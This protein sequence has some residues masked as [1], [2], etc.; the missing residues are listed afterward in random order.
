MRLR[1]R[2][3]D[4]RMPRTEHRAQFSN[5]VRAAV[6]R[7][8]PCT[9]TQHPTPPA[10]DDTAAAGASA[11]PPETSAADAPSDAAPTGWLAWLRDPARRD[12]LRFMALR[13]GGWMLVI[14]LPLVLLG[15]LGAWWLVRTTPDALSV[16]TQAAVR[17]TRIVSA[18]G[19]A[20]G[21]A[22]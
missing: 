8:E 19:G 12:S 13:I 14:L 3:N 5:P 22:G 7:Q 6:R 17:P 1:R 16:A 9:V 4:F 21:N 10:D 15:G 18:D 2:P 11:D 20:A